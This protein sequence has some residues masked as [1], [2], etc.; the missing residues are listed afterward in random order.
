[1]TA[2]QAFR[3]KAHEAGNLETT[4]QQTIIVE[5]KVIRIEPASP[6]VIYVPVYQ[7][8]T[9]VVAS[10]TPVITFAA[11]VVVGAWLWGGRPWGYWG[12][13]HWHRNYCGGYGGGRWRAHSGYRSG[14]RR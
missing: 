12:G 14:H 10:P 9:V 3:K 13:C 1:M 7:P 4:E 6:E 8:Q 5:Q 11:G 2:I